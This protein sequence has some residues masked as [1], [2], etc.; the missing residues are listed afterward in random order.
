MVFQGGPT[1]NEQQSKETGELAG[2]MHV[3]ETWK[4]IFK[5]RG[6]NISP[7]SR[8]SGERESK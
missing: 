2:T 8:L 6:N 5:F 4:E 1:L 3:G 7:F